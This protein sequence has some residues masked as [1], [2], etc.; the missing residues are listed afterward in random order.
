LDKGTTLW[1]NGTPP[2]DK[3]TT[4]WDNGTPPLDKGTTPWD[5]GITLWIN[6][7]PALH[8]RMILRKA[9]AAPIIS[10]GPLL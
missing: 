1:D 8:N 9:K 3:G 4:P 2:L 10:G 6:E 7:I 5:N